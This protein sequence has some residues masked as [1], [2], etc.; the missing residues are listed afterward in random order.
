[1][2]KAAKKAGGEMRN[3]PES[4]IGG[5]GD[6]RKRNRRNEANCDLLGGDEWMMLGQRPARN[7]R[8]EASHNLQ[9]TRNRRNE[10]NPGLRPVRNQRNEASR[11]VR[12]TQ[13]RRNEAK[14]KRSG[15]SFP[16]TSNRWRDAD[17]MSTRRTEPATMHPWTGSSACPS[18][19]HDGCMVECRI[20]RESTG[21]ASAS[22][23]RGSTHGW[24]SPLWWRP[25]ED[26]S[27]ALRAP[28]PHTAVRGADDATPRERRAGQSVISLQD[29]E[30]LSGRDGS[31]SGYNSGIA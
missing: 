15:E 17:P 3:G 30:E 6:R 31:S 21:W 16:I 22:G 28:S 11:A 18:F 14:I 26:A 2:R 19:A 25:D 5:L 1:M 9:P 20:A 23:S 29:R 10:A 12:P 13:N 7:R 24:P 4:G 27:P 8:N